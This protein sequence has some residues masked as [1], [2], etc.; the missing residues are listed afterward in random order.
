MFFFDYN[1]KFLCFLYVYIPVCF[2][3]C[4]INKLNISVLVGWMH[5]FT[6]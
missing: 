1:G 5:F 4:C 6:L 2:R 3:I